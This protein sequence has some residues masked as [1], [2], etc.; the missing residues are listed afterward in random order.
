M[1]G[2]M[3]VASVMGIADE[4]IEEYERLHAEVWPG[5]LVRISA[6]NLQNYSIYR[7]GNEL[8]SYY[9]Y[10]GDDYDA[11]MAAIAADPVTQRWW[12]LTT[13]LQR[14]FD[15]LAPGQWW[16]LPEIFHHD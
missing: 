4:N 15:G 8:F 1:S 14:P 9:E 6:S 2:V 7:F 11:D 3:R 5:V 13:P 16:V 10:V 12:S